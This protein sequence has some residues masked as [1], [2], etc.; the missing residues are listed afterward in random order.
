MDIKTMS[1]VEKRALVQILVVVYGKELT[2][3]MMPELGEY[4]NGPSPTPEFSD[5]RPG[6][7]A[8]A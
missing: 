2:R 1:D 3:I 6:E 4:L 5:F 8:E 7:L